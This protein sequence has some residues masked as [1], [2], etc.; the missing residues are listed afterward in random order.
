MIPCPRCCYV[1]SLRG[2]QGDFDAIAAALRTYVLST[3]DASLATG[4][5]AKFR[6]WT[7]K[8][9]PFTVHPRVSDPRFACAD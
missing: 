2:E 5:L 6:T 3:R 7:G 1:F 9:V 8:R 4:D